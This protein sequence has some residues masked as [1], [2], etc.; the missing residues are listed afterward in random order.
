[1]AADEPGKAAYALGELRV[2]LVWHGGGACLALLEGLLNLRDL[3][4]LEASNLRG[5][6]L[7]GRCGDG[8]GGDE[9]GMPVAAE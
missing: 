5:E 7:Q 1:M 3:G 6:L 9:L 4:A 2:A 8:Q